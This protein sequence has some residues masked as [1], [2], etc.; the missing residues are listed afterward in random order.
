[1]S[2]AEEI[3]S[4]PFA[5]AAS[6]DTTSTATTT[7]K[8]DDQ[9]QPRTFSP[10]AKPD[11]PTLKD[12][13]NTYNVVELPSSTATTPAAA[14][15]RRSLY[16]RLF[17]RSPE[18]PVCPQRNESS[19]WA[20]WTF[21][22]MNEMVSRGMRRELKPEEFPIV[23]YADE[24][25]QMST[26]LL[27]AWAK[28][29]KARGK[30]AKLWRAAFKVFGPPYMFAGIFYFIESCVKLGEGVTLGLLLQWF[31][32]NREDSGEG[33]LLALAL[34]ACVLTHAVLHHI[35]FFLGM[36][37]GM[38]L[39][40]A[41]IAAIYKKCL[42]LS[43]SN[44]SSTGL[45]TNLISNDVQR[46]ED[47]APF[48]QYAWLAPI[49]M[50]A[51]L[52][53]AFLQISWG[54][55]PAVGALLLVIPMQGAFAGQ[56]A[57]L[58][59]KLSP[60]R[61][62]RIKSISDMLS[63][64]MVVKLYAWEI[65]FVKRI[66]TLRKKELG[67]IKSAAVLRAIN[68][69]LYFCSAG[70]TSLFGFVTYFLIG[71]IL[72]PAKIFT[73]LTYLASCRL[74]VTNFFPKAIQFVSESIISLQRIE[75]FLSLPEIGLAH[76]TKE[77]IDFLDSL[78]STKEDS[79]QVML[80]IRNGNFAWEA[81]VKTL[82]SKE[83]VHQTLAEAKAS[84]ITPV[85]KDI[86]ITLREGEVIGIVGPVG[87]GKSSFLNA[88]LGEMFPLP[89]TQIGL[90]SRKIAYATQAPW[91][92]TGT[93][94]DNITF[95]LP[96]DAEWFQQ[97]ISACAMERDVSRFENGVDTVIGERGVTL[98]GGQRARLALARAVYFNADIV[99][100]DD[101]L[102]A[103]DAA[104]G[105]HLFEKCIRG[106]LKGKAII[107]VTHQL[108]YVSDC[109]HVVVIENGRIS[110][111]GP[112]QQVML[113]QDSEFSSALREY[114][115]R[116]ADMDQN[117]DDEEELPPPV[118][119]A[120]AMT[121][122]I[123]TAGT[124]SPTAPVAAAGTGILSNETVTK[125]SISGKTYFQYFSSGSSVFTT[126]VLFV[127]LVVGEAIAD[128][129]NWWLAHWSQ[130][131]PDQK[132]KAENA[133]VFFALVM[134]TIV[135]SNGRA[136]LF[137]YVSWKAARVLFEK[138]VGC[139]FKTDMGFFHRN[140]TGTIVNRAAKDINLL[141][142][143]LPQTFFDFIQCFFM[144]LGTLVIS[145]TVIPYVL[146]LVPFIGVAFFFLRTAYIRTSRQIKRIEAVT[147]SPVYAAIP[148]SLEGLSSIRAFHV[149]KQFAD[150]F[151]ALQN[152]NTSKYYM[153]L[154]CARWL[155]FRLDVGSAG[156]LFIVA[157][158]SV[159]LRNSLGLRP[160]V[161]GLLL[162]YVLQLT[163]L[164][165]WAVRQSAEVENYMVSVER[166]LEYTTLP[167]EETPEDAKRADDAAAAGGAAAPRKTWPERGAIDLDA[168]SLTYPGT[169]RAVLDHISQHIPAGTKVGIVG[170]TGAGKSSFLQALFRIVNP[171][172]RGS[173]AIDGVPT[174]NVRLQ[175]LRSRISIIPQE[176]FCFKGTL[177]FNIDPFEASTDEEIWRVLQLVELNER[178]AGSPEK[179]ES[180]VAEN[181][182]NWSVGERQLIC[183]ARAILR[184]TKL[185]VMD[186]A[187]SNV[188]NATD[189]KIQATMRR[190][191][192][193]S[194]VLTIAHRLH[195]VIDY[196]HILV[197][198]DGRLVESGSPYDLLQK[199]PGEPGAWFASM[200][201][202]MGDDARAMLKNTATKKEMERRAAAGTTAAIGGADAVPAETSVS[203]LVI[204]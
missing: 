80:A 2:T 167:P 1:M 22:F 9:Q 95:G 74:T 24:A 118:Q 104:V 145:V 100:L 152:D 114:A 35:V 148:S 55:F 120:A 17:R 133:W 40:V 194:T 94:R 84:A 68:E 85:L 160:G 106:I 150:R 156:F 172:P 198:D 47:A 192:T 188:D 121:A 69:A 90:R 83:I 27:D 53:L 197:L 186:E 34:S 158:A 30:D 73:C 75:A 103:V 45:I 166:V 66:N 49:E 162:S 71:G 88:L 8:A 190:C 102:S 36:R 161:I 6:D 62:E 153:F 169:T 38:Q 54:A 203:A 155:G 87:A 196:D 128:L 48:A 56:F 183:F 195:T 112:Y 32:K 174:C 204:E 26:R 21:G 201:G 138:M 143:M 151:V 147:R 185:I 97:V 184:N 101:C 142:E 42:V 180:E 136:L 177:R 51:T 12:A 170:R 3:S 46:F 131:A 144:I 41:F 7:F 146:I 20:R 78:T 57:K 89:G 199:Q 105:K 115:E 117:I 33:Y 149:E 113:N 76:G 107:L 99:L 176:P 67:Y 132:A 58:R 65:P 19:F 163:G 10:T 159:G 179:L 13:S 81:G 5:A 139:V 127:S 137:F 72:T 111:D 193:D 178:V 52:A 122:D 28:E 173:I 23:E 79:Q 165:Q 130:S 92:I 187:T 11:D 64:I 126:I 181:G 14:K 29:Q 4:A 108:Q 116:P 61:D 59:K 98:S 202:E 18:A 77:Q 119:K 123:P 15:N 91:I 109:D 70:I 125:G 110:G 82:E 93:V 63:G 16:E 37:M 141:D 96:Y 86:S 44:T 200:T 189:L 154:N 164:L 43:I 134:A 171:T 129:A 39:R 31:Q 182:G 175:D 157:I 135:I 25:E 124:T 60:C 50:L 168:F 140:S 191:F